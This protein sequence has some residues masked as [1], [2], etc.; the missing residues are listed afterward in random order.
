MNST[1]AEHS[2]AGLING[3]RL[4]DDVLRLRNVDR[5]LLDD[6]QHVRGDLLIDAPTS[7]QDFAHDVEGEG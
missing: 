6:T 2:Q 5:G 7:S 4:D 1:E 3:M